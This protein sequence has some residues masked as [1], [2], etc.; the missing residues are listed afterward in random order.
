MMEHRV[1]SKLFTVILFA[2]AIFMSINSAIFSVYGITMLFGQSIYVGLMIA[3][4]ELGKLVAAS[5]LYRYWYNIKWFLRGLMIMWV[6]ILM[7][8]TSGGIFSYLTSYY[9]S[10][11]IDL[12]KINTEITFR[13]GDVV[14]L[15][16]EKQFYVNEIAKIQSDYA[17]AKRKLITEYQPRIDEISLKIN[18]HSNKIG[19]LKLSLIQTNKEIG[20]LIYIAKLLDMSTDDAVKWFIFVIIFVFDPL[21]ISLIIASNMAT[22]ISRT[23]K[24][25]HSDIPSPIIPPIIEEERQEIDK[26]YAEYVKKIKQNKN[27]VLSE[28]K[29]KKL[30]ETRDELMNSKMTDPPVLPSNL[31]KIADGDILPADAVIDAH[32]SETIGIEKQSVL[33]DEIMPNIIQTQPVI[34][35]NTES[36]RQFYGEENVDNFNEEYAQGVNVKTGGVRA[37]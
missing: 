14:R 1:S 24:E 28:N 4:L 6:F 31:D 13:E 10:S 5:Y 8:I 2:S 12:D 26:L 33:S 32:D 36:Q 7:I 35:T 19:E 16:Q 17:S 18:D 25:S 15:N 11:A 21:A 30:P 22:V 37:R 34:E 20:P 29:K 27:T 23:E 9:Q 3:S